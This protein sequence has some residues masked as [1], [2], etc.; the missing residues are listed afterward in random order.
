[1]LMIMFWWWFKSDNRYPV[2][3]PTPCAF[4]ICFYFTECF[5]THDS[6]DSIVSPEL[7]PPD[8]VNLVDSMWQGIL[9]KKEMSAGERHLLADQTSLSFPLRLGGAPFLF[10]WR[11]LNILSQCWSKNASVLRP[12]PV[13]QNSS[14]YPWGFL[15]RT[16]A[17]NPDTCRAGTHIPHH[18]QCGALAASLGLG[19]LSERKMVI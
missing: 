10:S 6:R 14:N 15:W 11:K 12:H 16:V 8:S 9:W 2:C 4:F 18:G 1:M 19:I 13:F 5:S 3:F 7:P 17:L